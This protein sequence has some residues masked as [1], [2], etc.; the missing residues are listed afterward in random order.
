ML[1]VPIILVR[2]LSILTY[3]EN[4][5]NIPHCKYEVGNL[6]SNTVQEGFSFFV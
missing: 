1:Y 2:R 4:N 5:S 3:M 6:T